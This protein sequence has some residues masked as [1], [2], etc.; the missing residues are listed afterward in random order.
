MRT[1]YS[2]LHVRTRNSELAFAQLY[3]SHPADDTGGVVID[4]GS[5]ACKFGYAG[6]DV[7]KAVFPG[8]RDG[9]FAVRPL[10]P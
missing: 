7:P 1:S 3:H 5:Y 6:D 9:L 10:S 8:V 4:V 2:D